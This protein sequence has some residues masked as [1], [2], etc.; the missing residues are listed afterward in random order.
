LI[1]EV[2]IPKEGITTRAVPRVEP[3]IP[4]T[5]IRTEVEDDCGL[6]TV[7]FMIPSVPGPNGTITLSEGTAG[8]TVSKRPLPSE[9]VATVAR[10]PFEVMV[11]DPLKVDKPNEADVSRVWVR[12]GI[13]CTELTSVFVLESTRRISAVTALL[14]RLFTMNSDPVLLLKSGKMY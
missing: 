9:R 14:P 5:E 12:A 13:L 7:T 11:R 3:S 10:G 1:F 4:I 6:K 2:S 8:G